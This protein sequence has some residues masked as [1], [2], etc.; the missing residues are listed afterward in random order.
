MLWLFFEIDGGVHQVEI[1][2]FLCSL[3]A[4][5]G[6]VLWLRLND[7]VHLAFGRRSS[8]KAPLVHSVVVQEEIHDDESVAIQNGLA[9]RH[10]ELPYPA[11]PRS[12]ILQPT[13]VALHSDPHPVPVRAEEAI[14]ADTAVERAQPRPAQAEELPEVIVLEEEDEA[15]V[16][17]LGTEAN[18][19]PALQQQAIEFVADADDPRTNAEWQPEP[20]AALLAVQQHLLQEGFGPQDEIIVPAERPAPA[21]PEAQ[22]AHDYL[23]DLYPRVANA[24][25]LYSPAERATNAVCVCW[26]KKQKEEMSSKATVGT[27]GGQQEKPVQ[28]LPDELLREIF[29]FAKDPIAPSICERNARAMLG[30]TVRWPGRKDTAASTI[31]ASSSNTLST[32]S[33]APPQCEG[34]VAMA[35]TSTRASSFP[36]RTEHEAEALGSTKQHLDVNQRQKTQP[37]NVFTYTPSIF[38]EG[39]YTREDF[40]ILGYRLHPEGYLGKHLGLGAT[41]EQPPEK[42]A[43]TAPE[44]KQLLEKL[45]PVTYGPVPSF[46]PSQLRE[47]EFEVGLSKRLKMADLFARSGLHDVDEAINASHRSNFDPLNRVTLSIGSVMQYYAEYHQMAHPDEL[48]CPMASL[49]RSNPPWFHGDI[50]TV[51]AT[52]DHDEQK[53]EVADPNI[54][55]L[56][57]QMREQPEPFWVA[58]L[59]KA[60]ALERRHWSDPNSTAFG[61]PTQRAVQFQQEMQEVTLQFWHEVFL[62]KKKRNLY[63]YHTRRHDL[64]YVLEFDVTV[65]GETARALKQAFRN[66]EAPVWTGARTTIACQTGFKRMI[67]ILENQSGTGDRATIMQCACTL[68]CWYQAGA[69]PRRRNDPRLFPFKHDLLRAASILD[70]PVHGPDRLWSK[71]I[72]Y[73]NSQIARQEEWDD[74]QYGTGNDEPF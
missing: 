60:R 68:R 16:D 41:A 39:N 22:F 71:R 34:D 37:P 1:L 33:V 43:P 20:A 4:L 61:G 19:E 58:E 73:S 28:T 10:E 62:D 67:S 49:G 30:L 57:S 15:L 47:L 26:E 38:L 2:L 52:V 21:T 13:L 46:H 35:T 45:C 66:E 40:A 50:E 72:S 59:E 48:V 27:H 69:L 12:P 65:N 17:P 51:L 64:R 32:S 44:H 25:V 24:A 14:V 9:P 11:L 6:G 74:I 5:I 63:P 70:L 18:A 36:E 31:I 29:L 56:M 7:N 54:S 42:S 53:S 55:Q 3:F 23:N 8:R